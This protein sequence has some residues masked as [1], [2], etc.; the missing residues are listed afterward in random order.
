MNLI[1][2]IWKY[3]AKLETGK[4]KKQKDK[5]LEVE[6]Q[7]MAGL[8]WPVCCVYADDILCFS[9]SKEVYRSTSIT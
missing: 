6:E 1:L 2:E 4:M 7:A 8:R 3:A 9:R 5:K